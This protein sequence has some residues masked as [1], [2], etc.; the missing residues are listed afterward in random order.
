[1]EQ[2]TSLFIIPIVFLSFFITAPAYALEVTRDDKLSAQ[3]ECL[4]KFTALKNAEDAGAD[5]STLG[6]LKAGYGRELRTYNSI[7]TLYAK[8][9]DTTGVSI[10]RGHGAGDSSDVILD[11]GQP[12]PPA[13]GMKKISVAFV[14]DLVLQYYKKGEGLKAVLDEIGGNYPAAASP[15]D[16]IIEFLGGR[17]IGVMAKNNATLA[18]IR[19]F[20]D[21]KNPVICYVGVRRISHWIVIVGYSKS[22]MGEPAAFFVRDAFWGRAKNYK[23]PAEL[24]ARIWKNPEPR[25]AISLE[26]DAVE[27]VEN[28]L[29]AAISQVPESG[30]VELP[31]PPPPAEGGDSDEVGMPRGHGGHHHPFPPPPPPSGGGDTGE[32][33]VGGPGQWQG[34]NGRQPGGQNGGASSEIQKTLNEIIQSIAEL[35]KKLVAIAIGGDS[36]NINGSGNATGQGRPG[37]FTP[38]GGNSNGGTGR[39]LRS[40]GRFPIETITGGSAQRGTGY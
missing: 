27:T 30:E 40:R 1:M 19:E 11:I 26:G 23:I 21:A 7:A 24:F 32:T 34:N 14:I 17:D 36:G 10:G 20:I 12:K 31:P 9:G 39:P 6:E 18:D 15:K 3:F 5:A 25:K 8:N 37:G 35:Q 22:G 29:I 2:R 16:I 28:Y 13:D 4:S 38:D 33:G